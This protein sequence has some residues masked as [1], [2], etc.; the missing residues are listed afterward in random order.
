MYTLVGVYS[1]I[2]YANFSE[3]K[4]IGLYGMHL[5]GVGVMYISIYKYD[6]ALKVIKFCTIGTIINVYI[7]K[8]KTQ[9]LKN[10]V[11]HQG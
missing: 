7:S 5:N 10:E 4:L 1:G 2:L 11:Q 8:F 6:W 9:K 3:Q